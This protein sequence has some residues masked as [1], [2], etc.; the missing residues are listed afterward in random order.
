MYKNEYGSKQSFQVS[1]QVLHDMNVQNDTTQLLDLTGQTLF[2]AQLIVKEKIEQLEKKAKTETYRMAGS[3]QKD[4]F[5]KD[6]ESDGTQDKVY[7]FICGQ[8]IKKDVY[9]Y[10]QKKLNKEC[11]LLSQKAILAV[12]I[13]STWTIEILRRDK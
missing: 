7:V 10:V 6:D 3:I 8:A 11:H 5:F 1:K 2:N 12:R 13:Q 9:K 4:S